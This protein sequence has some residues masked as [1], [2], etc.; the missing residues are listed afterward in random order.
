MSSIHTPANRSR[1]T[2]GLVLMAASCPAGRIRTDEVRPGGHGFVY[3]LGSRAQQGLIGRIRLQPF[4]VQRVRIM[5][6]C[7]II[8]RAI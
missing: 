7:F 2:S 3:Q 6:E 4:Y 1:E 8:G 5:V